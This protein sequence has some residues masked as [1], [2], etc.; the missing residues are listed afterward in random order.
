LKIG[1]LALHLCGFEVL[2]LCGELNKV[3]MTA[4]AVTITAGYDSVVSLRRCVTSYLARPQGIVL[5][6]SK[7]GLTFSEHRWNSKGISFSEPVRLFSPFGFNNFLVGELSRE[8]GPSLF[9]LNPW[10]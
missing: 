10:V 4:Q 1:F 9:W 3:T 8:S 6:L 5:P 2:F 7:S